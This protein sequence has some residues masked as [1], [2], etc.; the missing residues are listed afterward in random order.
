M[1]RIEIVL[2]SLFFLSIIG[3][4]T[5]FPGSGLM[6]VCSSMLLALLYFGL[7]WFVLRNEH[8]GKK[9]VGLSVLLGLFMAMGVVGV[10]F[11]FQL[12]PGEQIMIVSSMFLLLMF[13]LIVIIFRG[14]YHPRYYLHTVVRVLVAI[15]VLLAINFVKAR[16]LINVYFRDDLKQRD[17]MIRA[18]EHPENEDYQKDVEDYW[19]QKNNYQDQ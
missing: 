2:V 19:K 13:G 9:H 5:A 4:L 12:W 15:V 3:K 1:K 18:Y 6:F 11:K 10:L 14:R 7:G 16:Y 17:L 8:S